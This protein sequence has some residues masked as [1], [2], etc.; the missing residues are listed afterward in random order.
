MPGKATHK[1]RGDSLVEQHL[2]LAR[3]L[4]SQITGERDPEKLRQHDAYGMAL[5]ALVSAAGHWDPAKGPFAPYASTI[6]TRAVRSGLKTNKDLVAPRRLAQQAKKLEARAQALASALGR[7]PSDQ[8]LAQAAGLAVQDVR[9]ALASQPLLRSKD[10]PLGEDGAKFE[11]LL[12]APVAD[13]SSAALEAQ[14]AHLRIVLKEL[15]PMERQILELRLG[16]NDGQP[17]TQAQV[18]K[19]L[20]RSEARV[21]QLEEGAR[22]KVK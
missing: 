12:Q 19:L 21:R 15:K 3:A 4:A 16:L 18:A 2:G 6:I 1:S 11:D 13:D 14:R 10:A 8:E 5:E 17:K 7:R 22:A 20:G 9:L